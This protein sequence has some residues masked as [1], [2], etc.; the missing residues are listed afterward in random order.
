MGLLCHLGLGLCE[1]GDAPDG[2]LGYTDGA[3][4]EEAQF[5]AGF[6]YLTTPVPGS[7]SN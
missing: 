6:P 3:L 2:Q 7:P 4:Q 5:D 1:P